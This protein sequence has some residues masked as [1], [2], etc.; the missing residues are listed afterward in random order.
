MKIEEVHSLIRNRRAVYPP[1]YNKKPI[2]G[3]IIREI[4]ENANWAPTHKLTEPWRFKVLLG[5]AK[6][7]FADFLAQKYREI[8]P[9]KQFT[10]AKY[11]KIK[12]NPRMAACIIVICMQRDLNERL[13][14]WEELAAVAASVQNMWL[15]CSAYNIGAYWSSPELINHVDEFFD[16]NPGERCIGLFYMGYYDS[17]SGKPSRK[18]I[19][20]KVFWLDK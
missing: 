18:P 3:N 2:P 4:L 19:E 13:P 15:T 12:A 8:T 10:R 14:E 6:A 1:N 5:D 11:D 9:E 16:L 7:R 20:K 17:F